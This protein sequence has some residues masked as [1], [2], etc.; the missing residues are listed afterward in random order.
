MKNFG[1]SI[2]DNNGTP[3]VNS[4]VTHCLGSR[5]GHTYVKEVKKC[6]LMPFTASKLDKA[7]SCAKFLMIFHDR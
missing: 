7:H 1:Q 4:R 3:Q 2:F 6:D 5:R